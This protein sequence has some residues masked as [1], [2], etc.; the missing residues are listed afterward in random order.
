M[1]NLLLTTCICNAKNLEDLKR[2][3]LSINNVSIIDFTHYVLLQ[4]CDD[5]DIYENEFIKLA[6]NYELKILKVGGVVSLS[7]ARNLLIDK[8]NNTRSMDEFD[9]ISFPD[10]DCWYPDGFWHNFCRLECLAGFDL[11]YTD[12]SS[13]PL[14][15]YNLKNEHSS[16][17]L[18]RYASSNTTIYKSNIFQRL[19]FFDENYGVGTSNNGGEDLD[20]AIRANLEAKATY[21]LKAPAVGHRDPLPEFRFK[22]FKG[23][24]GVLKKHKFKNKSLFFH[25]VRKFL[26]GI[27]FYIKRKIELSD[28]RVI[29]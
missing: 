8:V 13:K 3:I 1:R 12:F 7:K 19:G 20:Y 10:D 28:F 16:S 24:F 22:Y 11:F 25:F 17:N 6:S 21:F 14:S 5:F 23:S 9:F 2:L 15:S 29:S 26:I 27:M 18:I 4:N